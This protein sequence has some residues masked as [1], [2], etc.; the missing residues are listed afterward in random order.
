MT[1]FEAIKLIKLL[2]DNALS[3]KEI[4]ERID[5]MLDSDI[6]YI[7]YFKPTLYPLNMSATEYV[8]NE[9]SEVDL[10]CL[11]ESSI[12]MFRGNYELN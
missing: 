12:P 11:I 8:I 6:Y 1:R 3:D 7:L 2:E 10:L 9:N 4:D 5:S